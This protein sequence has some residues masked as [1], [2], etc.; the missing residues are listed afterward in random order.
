MNSEYYMNE[1]SQSTECFVSF[2]AQGK[3][4]L[5]SRGSMC[6]REPGS[7]QPTHLPR[8]RTDHLPCALWRKRVFVND[9]VS[10]GGNHVIPGQ[11]PPGPSGKGRGETDPS[12]VLGEKCDH[13]RSQVLSKGWGVPFDGPLVVYLPASPLTFWSPTFILCKMGAVTSALQDC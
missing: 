2:R 7:M 10:L 4:L 9:Y 11:A 12:P 8:A 6:M 3:R 13:G 5:P 1:C